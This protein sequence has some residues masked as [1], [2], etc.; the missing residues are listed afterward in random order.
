MDLWYVT[1]I[2]QGP[3][4]FKVFVFPLSLSTLVRKSAPAKQPRLFTLHT[5]LHKN[6]EEATSVVKYKCYRGSKSKAAA[7]HTTTSK[8]LSPP[9]SMLTSRRGWLPS[10]QRPHI[11][12]G[13]THTSTSYRPSCDR[14]KKY[15]ALHGRCDGA[16]SPRRMSVKLNMMA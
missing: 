8:L 3:S 14:I 10:V 9:P 7:L 2:G 16:S 6:W 5:I 11:V 4:L 1:T 13:H 12:L 15:L